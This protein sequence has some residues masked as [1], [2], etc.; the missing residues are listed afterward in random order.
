MKYEYSKI[1]KI[2]SIRA[3]TL[4]LFIFVIYFIGVCQGWPIFLSDVI[5]RRFK[6]FDMLFC[7]RIKKKKKN[8]FIYIFSFCT[9]SKDFFCLTKFVLL[10]SVL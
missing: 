10:C 3:T 8:G 6:I 9:E 4:S 2:L 5:L 7:Y 1:F